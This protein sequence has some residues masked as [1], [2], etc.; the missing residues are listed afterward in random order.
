MNNQDGNSMN[1]NEFEIIL[2]NRVEKNAAD[3][4]VSGI[5][6]WKD[7][8]NRILIGMVMMIFTLNFWNLNY[9][10]PM[11]GMLLILLGTRTLKNENIWFYG[12]WIITVVR[13][14][15]HIAN[16]M[17]KATVYQRSINE[18]SWYRGI[19][20]IE[21]ILIFLMFIFLR[22]AI[23]DVQSKMNLT[24]HTGA[25]IWMLLWYG[26]V[27]FLAVQ[28][29]KGIYIGV[30][31]LIAYIIIIRGLFQ[32]SKEIDEVGYV[33]KP[34]QYLM[35]ERKIIIGIVSILLLGISLGYLLFHSYPMDW[36]PAN[37]SDGNEIKEVKTHLITLGIPEEIVNDLKEEDILESAGALRAVVNKR[38]YPIRG[39][40]VRRNQ[41]NTRTQYMKYDARE[42]QITAIGIELEGEEERWKIIHH[43]QWNINPGF[44][45]TE[46]I[47]LWP[48]YQ[49]N[50]GWKISG[51]LSGQLLY[52][53][54]GECFV[55]PFYTLGEKMVQ[56]NDFFFGAQNSMDV[57]ATFSMPKSGENHRG[58]LSYTVDE[59]NDGWIINSW[60]NYTYQK[61]WKQYPV[62]T[63]KDQRLMNN[64]WMGKGAFELIQQQLLYNPSTS[65]KY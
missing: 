46:F 41:G 27:C 44:Y 54:K 55:A 25:I 35:S 31:M 49:L 8:M 26:A 9:I 37:L 38:D 29:Y 53:M 57:F 39:T 33:I 19:Q 50:E 22:K 51:E 21:V 5:T 23:Q 65:S 63:A 3:H 30:I 61:T 42:L 28:E 60:F 52:D 64:G 7:S 18:A 13:A 16:L 20:V 15:Y 34:A 32:L 47:Q 4:I 6:L 40:S 12:C 45:G 11:V 17:I 48:A 43:F 56:S 1:D 59:V 58:Y 36:K 62:M 24:L 10:F 14:I 2:E